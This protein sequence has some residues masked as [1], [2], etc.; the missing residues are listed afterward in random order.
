M[1]LFI[2]CLKPEAALK[3]A[4]RAGDKLV[5]EERSQ[6][7]HWLA[8]MFTPTQLSVNNHIRPCSH[9]PEQIRLKSGH[10]SGTKVVMAS[11]RHLHLGAS[12]TLTPTALVTQQN[13]SG[14]RK[15]MLN[16]FSAQEMK[17]SLC[18]HLPPKP[19]LPCCHNNSSGKLGSSGASG[20]CVLAPCICLVL[21][22]AR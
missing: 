12:R 14:S 3:I 2:S 1:H 15:W 7:N 18:P 11:F 16:G 22:E 21:V 20:M 10:R 5:I 19:G 6:K 4:D 8:T 9:H 13:L 17:L